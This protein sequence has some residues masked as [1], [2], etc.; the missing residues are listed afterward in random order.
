MTPQTESPQPESP[1]ALGQGAPATRARGV[2][3]AWT[4]A[5]LALVAVGLWLRAHP[6]APTVD[7]GMAPLA[8]L[9]T[10]ALGGRIVTAVLD[11]TVCAVGAEGQVWVGTADHAFEVRGAA[12]DTTVAAQWAR[13]VALNLIGFAANYG[14]YAVLIA[15]VPVVAANPVLGVAAG[16]VAGMFLNFA[17]ARR[18]VF[19]G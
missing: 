3:F 10:V 9:D 1:T 11:G 8:R 5:A 7:L 4:A 13:F 18:Y 12:R 6:P 15:S 19:R 16:S 2:A 17:V 14:T